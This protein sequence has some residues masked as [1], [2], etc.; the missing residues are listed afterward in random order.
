MTREELLTNKLNY[1]D[2][3]KTLIKRALEYDGVTVGDELTFREYAELIKNM[4]TG[5]VLLFE[6]EA[7]IELRRGIQAAACV[8]PGYGIS[9]E[10]ISCTN[11]LRQS[12]ITKARH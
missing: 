2:D 9:V 12:G 5:S 6:T 7:D 3:T 11:P 8:G 10:M 1:L 4:D